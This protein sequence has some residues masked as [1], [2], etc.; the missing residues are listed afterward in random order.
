MHGPECR[1]VQLGVGHFDE[2]LHV[3][4]LSDLL[5]TVNLVAEGDKP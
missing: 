2:S 4:A 5:T 1:D 3:L